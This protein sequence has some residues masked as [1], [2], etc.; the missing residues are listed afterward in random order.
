M[1]SETQVPEQEE[2]AEHRETLDAA[3]T[4]LAAPEPFPWPEPP[5]K[6]PGEP[7][8]ADKT[9]SMFAL[10]AFA[11]GFFFMRW[12]FFSWRGWGVSLF[13]ALYCGAV[14][15]YLRQKGVRM[16][17]AGYFWLTILLLTGIS[18]SLWE[19]NGLE[20]A[21]DLF[22]FLTAV[23]WVLSATGMPLLGKT[24][25]WLPLDG[26]HGLVV[27]PWRNFGSQYQ[28]LA[29]LCKNRG[30]AGK[31]LASI[32]LGLMLGL[33]VMATVLPLLI[34]ADSGG[35]SR[36][37]NDIWRYFQWMQGDITRLFLQ[38]LLAIPTAA[39]LFALVAGCAHRRGSP[40]F[41]QDSVQRSVDSLKILPA[42][43]VFTVLG[44]LS[45]LY[46]VFIGS[47][48]PYFFSAFVG[49]RPS[50]WQ[51]YS[52]Y[53]RNGFFELCSIA[54]INLAVLAMANLSSKRTGRDSV[55]LRVL[56]CLLALL[57]L[58]LIATAFSK[59]TLYI[60]V[61]GLS[62]RRLLPCAFMAFLAVV[63]GGIVALQRRK[64]SIMRLAA[65]VGAVMLCA[66]C[67]LNPDGLVAHYNANRYL[68][69][70]LAGFDVE[71][72]HRA[73][74][75]G[76]DAALLVSDR[77]SDETLRAALD[78]YLL[79]QQQATALSSGQPSDTLQNALARHQLAK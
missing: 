61:Y 47:Q 37:T 70:T 72:L 38:G 31:H 28:S 3:K 62:V 21:R 23:Y 76:V 40:S 24:S 59:M 34:K 19:N 17:R 73:G 52:E 16:T 33:I 56:N 67:L 4:A 43:T 13:T 74:P 7:F 10:V 8:V 60:K 11:L 41:Q 46:L 68:S 64:L 5:T 22:L 78:E 26:L 57:T 12:V 50:G 20:P 53:A 35:F 54:T 18:Y 77:T 6:Q 14:T 30:T 49:Q 55:A 45:G 36:I 29:V 9:D 63:C 66:L 27:I 15:L 44:L 69:G 65:G 71:I 79:G 39:Y 75:A 1:I 25:D 58:L 32:G 48:L 51:V 2:S 42:A